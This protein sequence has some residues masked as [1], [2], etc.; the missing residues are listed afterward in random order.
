VVLFKYKGDNMP[1]YKI[2]KRDAIKQGVARFILEC[3][4]GTYAFYTQ[5]K[6]NALL[7]LNLNNCSDE[8]VVSIIGNASWTSLQEAH[9][10][11]GCY[12]THEIEI[13]A[14]STFRWWLSNN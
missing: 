10:T 5:E 2:N 6:K 14:T 8:D 3:D 4:R 9:K 1:T 12:C 13:C 11:T 7:N